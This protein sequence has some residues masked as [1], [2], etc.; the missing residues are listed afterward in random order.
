MSA[1]LYAS[2]ITLSTIMGRFAVLLYNKTENGSINTTEE[3]TVTVSTTQL[4]FYTR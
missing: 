4:L 2:F 1:D 3:K